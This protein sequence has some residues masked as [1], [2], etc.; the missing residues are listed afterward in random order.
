MVRDIRKNKDYFIS[1]LEYQYSRLEKRTAKLRESKDDEEKK[2]R[3]LLS[4]TGYEIDL[5]KAEFSYG[6]LRDDLKTLL[7]RAIDL[8]KEYKNPTK[9]DILVL[10]ALSIILDVEKDAEKILRANAKVISED[11]LLNFFSEYIKTGKYE[12]NKSLGLDDEYSEL[13][14]VFSSMDREEYLKKY[15]DGWYYNHIGYAWYDS[16]LKDSDTYCGYWSFESSA[17][18]KIFNLKETEL[19]LCE[20][21]PKL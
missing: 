11:R 12:W 16:H 17:I 8:I 1:Y 13:D 6:A 10:L 20:Y 3:I 19:D 2:Q 14:K 7:I 4:V 18:A 21:Y 15:L 5:L 9:E